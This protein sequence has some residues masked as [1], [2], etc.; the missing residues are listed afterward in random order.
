MPEIT[1]PACTLTGK[2]KPDESTQRLG[3]GIMLKITVHGCG[4]VQTFARWFFKAFHFFSRRSTNPYNSGERSSFPSIAT[5]FGTRA[6]SRQSKNNIIE[7][8]YLLKC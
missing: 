2:T 6:T 4:L 7:S 5:R 8:K 1:C 3:R